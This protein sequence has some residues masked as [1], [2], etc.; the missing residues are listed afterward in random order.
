MCSGWQYIARRWGVAELTGSMA[1]VTEEWYCSLRKWSGRTD[2]P[3][4][5]LMVNFGAR[6]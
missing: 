5:Q 6:G 4:L 3:S 2:K 1:S